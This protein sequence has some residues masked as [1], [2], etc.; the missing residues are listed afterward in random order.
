MIVRAVNGSIGPLTAH[1]NEKRSRTARPAVLMVA[2]V[3]GTTAASLLLNRLAS[4]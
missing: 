2:T 3:A 4:K 1:N